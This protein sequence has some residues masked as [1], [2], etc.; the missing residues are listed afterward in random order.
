MIPQFNIV[1]SDL[2]DTIQSSK[3]YKIDFL[4]GRIL[5]KIDELESIKQAIYKILQTERFENVIYNEDYGI[6]LVRLIG[7]SKDFVKSDIERT[8]K[9]ALEVDERILEIKNF[10]IK[11]SEKEN[12]EISFE[13]NSLY[14]ILSINSEVKK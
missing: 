10:K 14:G 6:E 12:L 8:I 4:N 11:D 3:T 7:K 2:E 13:I 1:I 9:E 5:G